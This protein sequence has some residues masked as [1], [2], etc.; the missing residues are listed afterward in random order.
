MRTMSTLQTLDR[1]LTVLALVASR[2]HGVS[3][4]EISAALDVHRAITYRLVATLQAHRL[5]VRAA[6]GLVHL[7]AGVAGLAQSYLPHLG[8]QAQPVLA[9]LADE[10]GATAFLSVAEGGECVVVRTAEPRG[11]ALRVTYQP[12]TRHPLERGAPGLAILAARPATDADDDR[13][14]EARSLGYAVT[15]G[16]LQPGAVGCSAPLLVTTGAPAPTSPRLEA[17]V[18]VVAIGEL[19]TERAGRASVAAAAALAELLG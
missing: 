12:G 2:P 7:G 5:V 18:G 9:D 6:D 13:V 19:D 1:G 3:V 15:R 8:D 4:A 16:E 14:R 10:L 11:T 17:S